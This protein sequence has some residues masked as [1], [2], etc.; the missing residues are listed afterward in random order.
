MESGQNK[1]DL[2][3]MLQSCKIDPKRKKAFGDGGTHALIHAR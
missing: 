1:Y 2:V 3:S